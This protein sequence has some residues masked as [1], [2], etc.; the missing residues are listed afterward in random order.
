MTKEVIGTIAI[1]FVAL[2]ALV[3]YR[4]NRKL[5][6]QQEALMPEPEQFAGTGESVYYVATVFTERPLDRV[7]AHGLGMRGNA[8]LSISENGLGISRAGEQGFLIPKRDTTGL[9]LQTATIDKS[10]ERDGLIAVD[11]SLGGQ[12]LSTSFRVA[13]SAKRIEILSEIERLIGVS[14]G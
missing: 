10:V 7:W 4:S 5:R 2:V 13:N 14:I 11:W 6:V 8:L 9:H 3:I 12:N 1:A